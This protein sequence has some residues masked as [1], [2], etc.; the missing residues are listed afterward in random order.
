MYVVIR[1]TLAV[2]EFCEEEMPHYI[3]EVSR[4]RIPRT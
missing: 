1:P 3:S 2:E 4:S